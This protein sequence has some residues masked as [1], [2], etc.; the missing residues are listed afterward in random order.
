[1]CNIQKV[2]YFIM[3]IHIS[4]NGNSSQKCISIAGSPTG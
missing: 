4:L 2:E 1:M 3:K